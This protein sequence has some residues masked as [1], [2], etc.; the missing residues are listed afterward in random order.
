M[1]RRQDELKPSPP[2]T[3]PAPPAPPAPLP[4]PRAASR[5]SATVSIRGEITA[6]DDLFIDGEV[7]GSV[8]V[9]EAVV[10]I[11]PRG[12]VTADVE[13]KGIEVQGRVDGNLRGSDRVLLRATAVVTGEISAR[14]IAVEEGA[15]FR[16]KAETVRGEEARTA[17]AAAAG[18][19][20]FATAPFRRQE[21]LG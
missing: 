5:L 4:E 1:W 12:R 15:I 21:S 19:E 2:A 17:R 9:A 14:R 16:G 6:G 8:R 20:A 3:H 13:A 11:G 7:Q 10:T 18:A